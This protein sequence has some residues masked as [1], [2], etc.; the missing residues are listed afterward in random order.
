MAKYGNSGKGLD[1]SVLSFGEMTDGDD[2]I[3][4]TWPTH[5]DIGTD[6]TIDGGLGNDQL[7][8]GYGNDV[9]IG[10]DGDDVLRGEKGSDTLTG[11]AGSDTFAYYHPSDSTLSAADTVTDFTAEDMFDFSD[12]Q[13]WGVV[14]FDDVTITNVGTD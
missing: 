1:V 7:F 3:H 12:Y 5:S 13:S 6:E 4:G 2:V 9:L 8:G 11:G 14:T 10:G